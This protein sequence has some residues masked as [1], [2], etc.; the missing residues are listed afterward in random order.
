MHHPW[1]MLCESMKQTSQEAIPSQHR[2]AKKKWMRDK[3]LKMVGGKKGRKSKIRK[4][5]RDC[6]KKQ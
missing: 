1:D 6:T 4:N 5:M 3:I 2:I